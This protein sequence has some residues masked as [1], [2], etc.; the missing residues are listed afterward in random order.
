MFTLHAGRPPLRRVE[1][2]R[3]VLELRDHLLAERRLAAAAHRVGELH[4]VHVGLIFTR[5]VG[6][7]RSR[8]ASAGLADVLRLPGAISSSAIQLRPSGR[9]LLHLRRVDV[10]TQ[11]RGG[12]VQEWR[13][14]GDRHCFLKG[15]WRHLHVDGRRLSGEDL[16][17]R[18]LDGGKRRQLRRDPIRADADWNAVK[19]PFVTDG[20]ESVARGFEDCRHCDAGKH[21]PRRI[22]DHAVEGC[23]LRECTR[24]EHC[25]D[26]D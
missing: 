14:P 3:D 18:P 13:F 22:R 10:A 25:E 16:N 24:R 19:A 12:D 15:G 20:D 23:F 6:V 9:H 17:G 8:A 4:A 2:V 5:A 11:A 7:S 21:G 1:A 26:P